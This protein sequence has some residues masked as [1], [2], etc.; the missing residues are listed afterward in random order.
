MK[1]AFAL[2][3]LILPAGYS[4]ALAAAQ[5]F[6]AVS[7]HLPSISTFI[8]IYVAAGVLTLAFADYFRQTGAHSQRAHRTAPR[9]ETAHALHGLSLTK[10]PL[11]AK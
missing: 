6:G 3:S 8:G 2:S 7:F 1:N 5:L 11:H 10:F 4:V 9:R